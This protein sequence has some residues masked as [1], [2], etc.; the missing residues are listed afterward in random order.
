M[1]PLQDG[2]GD[3]VTL[4]GSLEEAQDGAICGS[5]SNRGV[6]V[7][8]VEAEAVQEILY[9]NPKRKRDLSFVL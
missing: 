1:Q 5:A 6:C 4:H 3:G 8:A 7:R 2:A 9:F